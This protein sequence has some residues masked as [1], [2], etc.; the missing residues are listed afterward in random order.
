MEFFPRF[1]RLRDAP[2]Y[3]GMDKNRFNRE[4]RPHLTVIPIGT[5]GIAFDRVELD[6]WVDEYKNRNGR[7]AAQSE[8]RESWETEQTSGLTKRGGI[9]HIDKQIRGIRIR[10]STGTG[11]SQGASI[12]A[13]RIEQV[14]EARLYGVRPERTFRVAATKYL[15]E[16]QHKK[17]IGDDALHLRLLDP[18]IGILPL[19]QVHMGSLQCFIAQRQQQGRKVKSINASLAVVRRI[20]NLASS[21]WIDERGLTWLEAAPKIKL[22]PITD[23]RPPYPLS[24]EEQA[25]LFQELPAHLARMALFKVNTG[26]REQEVCGLRWEYE[27]KVPE[28]DTSVF[29]IPGSK[30]KN[31]EERLVVLNRVARSVIESVRGMHPS[32]RVRVQEEGRIPT[33]DQDEQLSLEAGARAGS[34]PVAGAVLRTG[35]RRVQTSA[36]PRFEAHIRSTPARRRR[37]V[38]GSSGP[39]RSQEWSDHHALLSGRACEP[40]R[41]RGEGLRVRVPQNSRKHMASAPN[42]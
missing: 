10:E 36:G 2:A 14:R 38:R 37:V 9:W 17:S 16:N 25:L 23:A 27:V 34:G 21:E 35:T 26:C 33:R 1:V 19:K 40:D 24:A 31:G 12:L 22:L 3:L 6:A 15:E 13:K 7:P 18:F 30:V 5:Q 41:R 20:L 11:T 42:G 4:V 32:P 28:L 29:I 39:A 8:R